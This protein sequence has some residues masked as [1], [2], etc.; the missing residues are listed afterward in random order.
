MFDSARHYQLGKLPPFFF[1]L[2][3]EAPLR[4]LVAADRKPIRGTVKIGI[5]AAS[6]ERASS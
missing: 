3:R 2:C 6:E 1:S 4:K 5:L